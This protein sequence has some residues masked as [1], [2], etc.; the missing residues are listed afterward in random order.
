GDLEIVLE[1][2]SGATSKLAYGRT[3]LTGRYDNWKF[4]TVKHLDE[5]SQGTWTLKIVDQKLSYTGTLTGWSL[6]IA[7]HS[8]NI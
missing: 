4:S 6:Q 8:V 2:P 7:G 5:N 1:S 3:I